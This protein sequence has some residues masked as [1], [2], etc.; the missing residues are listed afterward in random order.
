MPSLRGARQV[1]GM[2][3]AMGHCKSE[4]MQCVW[5][6]ADG[7]PPTNFLGRKKNYKD[8]RGQ[9]V[10]LY[11]LWRQ[12]KEHRMKQLDESVVFQGMPSAKYLQVCS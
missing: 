11:T 3:G 9:E 12:I 10:L 1:I 7:R 4:R 6:T 5:S 2:I 8:V